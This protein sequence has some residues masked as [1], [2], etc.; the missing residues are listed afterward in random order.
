MPPLTEPPTRLALRRPGPA[1]SRRRRARI[2]SEKP[3]ARCSMRSWMRSA[4]RSASSV[5]HDPVEISTCIA[6]HALRYMGEAQNDSVPSGD[7]VG[8]AVV[9][10]P[11][12]RNG[13]SGMMPALSWAQLM[14]SSSWESLICTVPGAYGGGALHGTGPLSA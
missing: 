10:C 8:S 2:R 12:S 14:T 13:R 5:A 6:E 7:R 3:G 11:T 1:G 9:I 4:N